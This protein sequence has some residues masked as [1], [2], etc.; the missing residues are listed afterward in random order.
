MMSYMNIE[1]VR[2]LI[3]SQ[4][5]LWIYGLYV[6]V[7]LVIGSIS[8]FTQGDLAWLAGAERVL[9]YL[10]APLALLAAVNVTPDIEVYEAKH[11][12]E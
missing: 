12:W 6:L 1:A 3:P 4:A 8:A 5:R 2:E 7:A 9:A 10:A 11:N